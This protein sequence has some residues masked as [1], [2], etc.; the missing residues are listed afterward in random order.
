MSTFLQDLVEFCIVLGI[1]N[2]GCQLRL[3]DEKMYGKVGAKSRSFVRRAEH[4]R[5]SKGN[6]I[7]KAHQGHRN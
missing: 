2:F 1:Y 6:R 3:I 5:S 4:S 7:V